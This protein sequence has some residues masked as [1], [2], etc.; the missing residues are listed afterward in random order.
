[1]EGGPPPS[2][3]HLTACMRVG[4]RAGVRHGARRREGG[5]EVAFV[6]LFVCLFGAPYPLVPKAEGVRGEGTATEPALGLQTGNKCAAI[7]YIG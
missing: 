2:G 5:S 6:C 7:A 1:M 3:P 4:V